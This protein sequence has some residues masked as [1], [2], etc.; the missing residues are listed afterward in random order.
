LT[1]Q[2]LSGQQIT[3]GTVHH[4][5]AGYGALPFAITG[6][7][8]DPAFFPFK[9]RQNPIFTLGRLSRAALFYIWSNRPVEGAVHHP[10]KPF[11][12]CL[13]R[14]ARNAIHISS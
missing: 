1:S 6:N 12:N 9:E 4:N 10:V 3:H 7:Y 11:D 2:A 8:I 14:A 5:L 13:S